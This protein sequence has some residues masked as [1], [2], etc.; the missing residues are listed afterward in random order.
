MEISDKLE[1]PGLG[2]LSKD[3]AVRGF[4]WGPLIYGD[5]MLGIAILVLGRYLVFRCL[6]P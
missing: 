5:L 6:D 2:V 1:V 4:V 3:H